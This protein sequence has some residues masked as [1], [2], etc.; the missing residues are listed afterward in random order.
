MNFDFSNPE[1]FI[2]RELSWLE[3]NQ[4]VLQEARQKDTPLLEKIKFLAI[5]SSN[6]DEFFMIRVASLKDQVQANYK[7]KDMSGMS[8]KEQLKAISVRNN[9]IVTEQ[10]SYYKRSVYPKLKEIGIEILS[11]DQLSQ[12][13]KKQLKTYFMEEVF[14][15]LTP[16][17]VDSSRPFPL[18]L[19]KTLNIG[20]WLKKKKFASVQIPTNIARLYILEKTEDKIKYVLLEDIVK[21][22]IDELFVGEKIQYV[23]DY[24]ITRNADIGIVE[25][26]ADDLLEEIEKSL[27]KRKWGQAIR[28]EIDHKAPEEIVNYLKDALEIHSRDIYYIDGLIDMTVFFK[29]NKIAIHDK[30]YF[31][32]DTPKEDTSITKETIFKEIQKRDLFYYHP[33]ESF[34]PVIQFL[35]IAAE[36]PEV[37]AIKQTLYR[38]SGDSPVVKALERAAENGKQVTVIVEL[39]ARFDEENNIKWAKQLEKAGCHVIYG[40]IGYKVHSKI[41]LIVRKEATGIQRYVHLGTGNYNDQTAKIYADMSLMTANRHIGEDASKFFNTLS[42]YSEPPKMHKLYMS[43]TTLF[44]EV[45]ELIDRETKNAIAKKPARIIAKMNS[46]VDKNII[47]ALYKASMAGVQV[48]LIIRGICCLKPGI[49]DVSENIYV[50]SIVGKYLEH[51]RTFYFYNEGREEIYNSSADWMPRNLYKRVE[52]M[53]PIEDPNIKEKIKQILE[54]ELKDTLKG[55]ILK[56]DGKYRFEDKRGKKRINSQLYFCEE[57]EKF[58]SDEEIKLIQF[59]PRTQELEENY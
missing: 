48:D 41:T 43:P 29:I 50:K 57:V 7:G 49:K 23:Y 40:L 51:N 33:Y 4:R 37:L 55:R 47:E 15:I 17:A 14:P 39:K 32:I 44:N 3:F 46:L 1:Y 13:Q 6:L 21:L 26:E 59:K 8:A 52:L 54:I 56:Q 12:S 9:E 5:T 28:L 38:V 25:E 58:E 22:F 35:E 34:K 27:K 31:K 18:I 36:D 11:K 20:V 24:R 53:F 42:G 19:N 16:L 2:N 30:Y 45:I 10:Y